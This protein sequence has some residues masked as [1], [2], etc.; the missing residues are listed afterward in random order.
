VHDFV[1]GLSQGRGGKLKLCL[2]HTMLGF[3]MVLRA[4]RPIAR[5]I[6]LACAYR[7]TAS[8]RNERIHL[9][10]FSGTRRKS[11]CFRGNTL[12]LKSFDFGA[13]PTW[14]PS[15]YAT[16]IQRSVHLCWLDSVELQVT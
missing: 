4:C 16:N 9:S 2:E 10:G 6:E 11:M 8:R 12:G 7:D 1:V 5:E 15:A 14:V 3:S 13:I